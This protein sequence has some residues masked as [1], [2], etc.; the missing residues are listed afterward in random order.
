MRGLGAGGSNFFGNDSVVMV[1][2]SEKCD[3]DGPAAVGIQG[4]LLNRKGGRDF[5]TLTDFTDHVLIYNERQGEP[6]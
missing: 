6:K 5:T 3:H 4:F 1:G 2:D